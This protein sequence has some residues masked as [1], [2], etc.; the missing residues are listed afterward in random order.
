MHFHHPTMI[1][2]CV[3]GMDTHNVSDVPAY[4]SHPR[5][6]EQN[7]KNAQAVRGYL[8]ISPKSRHGVWMQFNRQMM[9]RKGYKTLCV[10]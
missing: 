8:A 1:D 7:L 10:A 3:I 4:S 6:Q 2:L 9:H 5:V